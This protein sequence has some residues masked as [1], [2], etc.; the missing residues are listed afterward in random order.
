MNAVLSA[1]GFA[2][3]LSCGLVNVAYEYWW[4]DAK[5]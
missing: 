1:L 3:Q 2:L 4:L 5:M